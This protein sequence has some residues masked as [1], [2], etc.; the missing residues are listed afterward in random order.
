MKTRP[1]IPSSMALFTSL[2][3]F[4]GV[5]A[6]DQTWPETCEQGEQWTD[7]EDNS[8]CTATGTILEIGGIEFCAADCGSGHKLFSMI[9]N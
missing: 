9:D 1:L 2:A 5:V 8:T 3:L 4:V 7:Q 6:A